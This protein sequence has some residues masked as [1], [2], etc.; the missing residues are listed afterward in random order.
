MFQDFSKAK[1]EGTPNFLA[2]EIRR[3]EAQN[4]IDQAENQQQSND[5]MGMAKLYNFGMGDERS[6]IA[7]ALNGWMGG[8]DPATAAAT[9]GAAPPLAPQQT[10]SQV[11][12]TVPPQQQFNATPMGGP[13]QFSGSM[14]D[15]VAPDML[16]PESMGFGEM[17]GGP[18][19]LPDAG[20]GMND[21]MF[22]SEALVP[23]SM[24]GILGQGAGA[25]AGTAGAGGAMSA[26]AGM[27][28]PLSMA[29]MGTQLAD[30]A[31]DGASTEAALGDLG[32]IEDMAQMAFG[33]GWL[34]S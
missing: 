10:P 23:E 17:A 24:S 7:D 9:E 8:G 16:S 1:R 28:N 34:W 2:A 25:G 20:M 6:P 11:T 15:P 27:M 22:G 5:L 14:I 3:A 21:A 31:T 12:G 29:L 33:K 13:E 18:Q 26:G 19:V 4:Q 30:Q 32:S